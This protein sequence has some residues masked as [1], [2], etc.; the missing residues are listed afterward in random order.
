MQDTVKTPLL[1]ATLLS[2]YDVGFK[3]VQIQKGNMQWSIQVL[4]NDEG[5]FKSL[6]CMCSNPRSWVIWCLDF[7]K[8]SSH[9]H[10]CLAGQIRYHY[11]S[12]AV[13]IIVMETICLNTYWP[14]MWASD[15]D[16][17]ISVSK[18]R[19]EKRKEI[20]KINL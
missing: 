13:Q 2:Y 1:E 4:P 14:W 17:R 5:K 11:H 15:I 6:A 7:L 10:W 20:F 19:I 3:V 18:T 8:C 16:Y 9:T 12:M